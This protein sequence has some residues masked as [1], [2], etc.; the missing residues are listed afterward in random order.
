MFHIK[1]TKTLFTTAVNSRCQRFGGSKKRVIYEDVTGSSVLLNFLS[2]GNCGPWTEY[3]V[4]F[5]SNNLHEINQ[6]HWTVS[7]SRIELRHQPRNGNLHIVGPDFCFLF[8][9]PKLVNP[10]ASLA[11][12]TVKK[13]LK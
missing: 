6:F 4:V 8:F 11:V 7:N 9:G 13:Y 1:G 5:M 12:S 10:N 2:R 3:N